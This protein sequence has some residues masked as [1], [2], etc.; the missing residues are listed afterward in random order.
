MEPDGQTYLLPH[1]MFARVIMTVGGLFALILPPWELGRALWPIN[2][3]SPFFAII[4]FG[5]MSVGAGF[6]YAGVM[7]PSAR[8]RFAPGMIEL[9]RSFLWG[10]SKTVVRATDITSFS[11]V[12]RASSDGPNDWYAVITLRDGLELPS[13]P[14]GRREAA[15]KLL[16]EF[17]QALQLKDA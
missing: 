3:L 11:V 6:L 16:D 8:L 5:G 4:V 14:L 1:P 9:T 17:R 15:E 12:E 2:L 13:R 10:A 7:A